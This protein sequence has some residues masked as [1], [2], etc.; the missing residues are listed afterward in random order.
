MVK[1]HFIRPIHGVT[2]I[3]A[4]HT[5]MGNKFCMRVELYGRKEK[6]L[7]EYLNKTKSNLDLYFLTSSTARFFFSS[8]KA[9][10]RSRRKKLLAELQHKKKKK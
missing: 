10:E 5:K 8:D 1:H 6:S 2:I 4:V 7:G 3:F 9:R